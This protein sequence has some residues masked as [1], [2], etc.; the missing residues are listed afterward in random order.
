MIEIKSK[1]DFNQKV[2]F[3]RNNKIMSGKITTMRA[4]HY[5][6]EGRGWILF[7][8]ESEHPDGFLLHL[9]E[10]HEGLIFESKKELVEHLYDEIDK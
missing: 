6:G 9:T 3:I 7:T 4:E 5:D 8:I 10:L 1:F 2:W